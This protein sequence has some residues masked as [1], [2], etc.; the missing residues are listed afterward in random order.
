[1]AH[2]G[3]TGS[4]SPF[5]ISENNSPLPVEFLGMQ[6]DCL[7][8]QGVSLT[9]QTA[10]EMNA[11][12]FEV[13]R[14][15]D[16]FNSKHIG[17]VL[18]SGTTS[19]LTAYEFIDNSP[20]R[21]DVSYY[22]LKQVDLDGDVEWLPIISVNCEVDDAIRLYPNPAQSQVT[23]EFSDETEETVTLSI[24]DALGREVK[25]EQI[26]AMI[27]FNRVEFNVSELP[28][29]SYQLRLGQT[30]NPKPLNLLINR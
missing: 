6:Y 25:V 7:G 29:G 1:M 18:A 10:S 15:E 11:Q 30:K 14:S 28:A 24:Y 21:A 19:L 26:A 3:Y 8:Q 17:T 23:I 12:H 2:T 4:F 27:G 13:M 16:G 9:W 22:Q 20:L 5:A